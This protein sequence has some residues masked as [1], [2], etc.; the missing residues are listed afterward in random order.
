[1]VYF[2]ILK[3]KDFERKPADLDISL[4]SNYNFDLGKSKTNK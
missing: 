2:R 3:T 1:M 4:D